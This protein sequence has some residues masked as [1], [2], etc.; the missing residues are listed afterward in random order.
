MIDVD[1][2]RGSLTVSHHQVADA[3]D[4]LYRL[5]P[6]RRARA[7]DKARAVLERRDSRRAAAI[8]AAAAALAAIALPTVAI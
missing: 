6:E 3:S 5:S 1:T 8:L 2:P 4:R 7:G